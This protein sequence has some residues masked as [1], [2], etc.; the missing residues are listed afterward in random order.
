[1][2]LL[3][4]LGLDALIVW[5]VFTRP[6]DGVSF[7]GGVVVLCSLPIIAYVGFR[8]IG[9][10]TLEY[11]VDRDAV[12]VIWAFTRQIIPL[13]S[14][15]HFVLNPDPGQAS[16]PRWWHWPC[17]ERS[18]RQHRLLGVI[19]CYATAPLSQQV[20]MMTAN[21]GFSVSPRDMK[22]FLDAVQTRYALGSARPL[23][24]ELIRPPVWTWP[25]WRDRVAMTLIGIGLVAVLVMFGI[26]CFRFPSLSS[27]LPLHFNVNGVPDRI[28]PKANLF[29]LPIIGLIAWLLNLGAGIWIYR[30]VQR[31]GAY[32]L[33]AGSLVV[34]VIAGL[35]LINLMR[36]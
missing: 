23:R 29:A 36:W 9:L 14:I 19:N 33:W 12:T 25:L 30:R 27:D 13:T 8:T 21:E 11:W 1:M 26:L 28:A 32:L 7:V 3:A 16:R 2:G 5:L 15:Q 31:G 35:A 17:S 24:P 34:Q 10:F 22:G 4:L 18:R 20:V 6:V